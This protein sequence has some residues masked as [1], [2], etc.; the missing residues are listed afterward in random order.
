MT[1]FRSGCDDHPKQYRSALGEALIEAV[2]GVILQ[3]I[4]RQ[5]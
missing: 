5:N 4:L 1:Y 2:L 3:F